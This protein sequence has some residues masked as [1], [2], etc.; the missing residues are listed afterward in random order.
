MDEQPKRTLRIPGFIIDEDIGLGGI[1]KRA[2]YVLGVK[3]CA[4]CDGRASKLDKIL[5]FSPRNAK[6]R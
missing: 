5:T 1:T 3:P 4:G 2:L 6:R